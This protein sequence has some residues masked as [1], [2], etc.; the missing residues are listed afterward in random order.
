[1]PFKPEVLGDILQPLGALLVHVK[2]IFVPTKV[3]LLR[4]LKGHGYYEH[5]TVSSC[6]I[7]MSPIP[8]ALVWSLKML[9]QRMP[10]SCSK[11]Q[12]HIQKLDRI[13]F[14]W[15][16]VVEVPVKMGPRG[17]CD[18]HPWDQS[19]LGRHTLVTQSHL[20]WDFSRSTPWSVQEYV[21]PRPKGSMC[22]LWEVNPM[23]SHWGWAST[24]EAA[25]LSK[26]HHHSD[27]S[28]VSQTTPDRLAS[29]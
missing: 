1:M 17:V 22:S 21:F 10:N 14:T 29:P 25:E 8:K 7:K 5:T 27:N 18:I 26:I 20:K 2:R 11:T 4:V 9:V 23:A 13:G 24:S 12:H 15:E 3:P 16:D 19:T 28:L 6:D